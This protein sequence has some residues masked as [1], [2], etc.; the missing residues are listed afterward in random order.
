MKHS[1]Q[2]H[3]GCKPNKDHPKR[4]PTAHEKDSVGRTH[5]WMGI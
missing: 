2:D 1:D 3:G 5:S 4:L